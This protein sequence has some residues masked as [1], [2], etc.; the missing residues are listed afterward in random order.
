MIAINLFKKLHA[1]GVVSTASYDKI[2]A[3]S[4]NGL[5]SVQWEIKT[6]LY[7]GVLLLSGGLGILVYKNID[8]IGHQAILAFIALL[9]AGCFYYCY[10]TK[11]PF[12]RGKVAA[13]NSFFDYVLLLGCLT[14]ISFIAYLQYQYNVFGNRYGLATFIP[15][16]MLFFTAYYFDHLGIL[17][18]A[19]TSFAAWMGLTITPVHLMQSN[20]FND[21][22]I[23]LTAVGVGALL[24]VA[25][26]A[27]KQRKWKAHF[28]F[29]YMNF[30]THTLYVA[31][32]AAMFYFEEIGWLLWFALLGA[33]AFYNYKKALTQNSFYLLLITML[34]AYVGLSYVVIRI[35]SFGGFDMGP[36]YL[37]LLYFIVSA[38]WLVSFLIKTNKKFKTL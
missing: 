38:I 27:T 2:K 22:R 32:L 8:T 37:G 9:C 26:W 4:T 35:L 6:I 28:E 34:Y 14:F 3:E 23:I 31:L 25:A 7:L 19:I 21:A 5:L 10:K 18:M 1:E 16:I 30:G 12:S 29:T 17:S 11:L 33:F 13:P 24:L 15:M 36:V 20:D